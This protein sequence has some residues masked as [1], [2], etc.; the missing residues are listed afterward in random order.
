MI[1]H[2]ADNSRCRS[3]SPRASIRSVNGVSVPDK[4]KY[5]NIDLEWHSLRKIFTACQLCDRPPGISYVSHYVNEHPNDE[6]LISRLAPAMAESLRSPQHIKNCKIIRNPD[7]GNYEYYQFCFFCNVY[8]SYNK[9]GWF[10]HMAVHTGYYLFECTDCLRQFA[11]RPQQHRCTKIGNVVKMPQRA[12]QKKAVA[13]EAYVCDLC[14]YVR[15][16][17]TDIEKH[18]SNEHGDD[19]MK[20]KKFEF[21]SFPKK[22]RKRGSGMQKEK[23]LDDF[24]AEAALHSDMELEGSEPEADLISEEIDS[25]Y[26]REWARENALHVNEIELDLAG[27]DCK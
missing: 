25:E 8:K 2:I 23:V 10:N 27:S 1:S 4:P 17:K 18:L 21:L 20:F 6:V 15:F 16:Y 19:S 26:E 22:K 9:G 5:K 14:N 11:Y 13:L 7:N 3:A 24:L 12:F